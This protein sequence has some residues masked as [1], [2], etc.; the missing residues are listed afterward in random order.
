MSG[1]STIT[2]GVDKQWPRVDA[3]QLSDR[4][5]CPAGWWDLLGLD[6]LAMVEWRPSAFPILAMRLG[7]GR[8][9]IVAVDRAGSHM[10][11]EQGI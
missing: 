2:R 6:G 4:S 9:G 8:Y 10:F 11:P 7:V 5:F 1:D 3:R